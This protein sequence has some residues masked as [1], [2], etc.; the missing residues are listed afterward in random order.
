M[1]DTHPSPHP[2]LGG[3]ILGG[4]APEERA[5]FEDHLS[6]CPACRAEVEEL[7]PLPAFLDAAAPPPSLPAD[8][9][10]RT[11]AAVAAAPRPESSIEEDAPGASPVVDLGEARA[12]PRRRWTGPLLAAG[13]VAASVV[14]VATI[15]VRS[16]DGGVTTPL[17]LGATSGTVEIERTP[18]GWRIELAIELPRR[19]GGAYYEAFL[20]GP[21]GRVPVGTFNEGEDVTLWAGVPPSVFR[22]FV[23]VAQ[24]GDVEVGRARL[25]V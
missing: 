14:L 24:P 21:A 2:D 9:R 12:R 11:L 25:R 13:A 17:A 15:A 23:I 18:S 4:L 22:D 8:L 6:R 16:G 10:E 3:F 20:E 1:A 19:D 5:G 7:R